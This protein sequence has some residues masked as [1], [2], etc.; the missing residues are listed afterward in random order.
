MNHT[1]KT[2][3]GAAQPPRLLDQVRAAIKARHYSPRT[4][5]AYSDWIVKFIVFS[6]RRHPREMGEPEVTAYLTYL[7]TVRKVAASTQN[8]ALAALLFLYR[9]VL[10]QDL[11]WLYGVVRAKPTQRI[12]VVLTRTETA[13]LLRELDGIPH[14][15]AVLLYGAGLRLNEALQ[16]RIKDVDF[17]GNELTVRR[18]KGGKDRRTMLPARA[19][20]LLQEQIEHVRLQHA[21]DLAVG[22]GYVALPDAM[23]IKNPGAAR[24]INWQWVFPA[25]RWYRVPGT[26]H[27]RRHHLHESVVQDAIRNARRRAGLTKLATSHTLRH[28]FATHLLESGYDIR[29]IQELLGHNDVTTT[30]MYTHVL[31]KGGRGVKSPLDE[32]GLV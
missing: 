27:K 25:T 15:V 23:E 32:E 3:P 5:K 14:V 1:P 11:P 17:H 24:D 13:A 7:A 2:T 12:P 16:M 22:A 18:G 19:R 20:P 10:G 30:M 8:Q 6:G 31:N 28:S 26:G 9:D 21:K 29:T 4:E